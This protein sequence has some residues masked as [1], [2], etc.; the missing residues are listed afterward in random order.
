MLDNAILARLLFA[1]VFIFILRLIHA[2]KL[3][4]GSSWLL[5][6]LGS[7]V[8]LMVVWP[9]SARLF[10]FVT[11]SQDWLL[12]LLFVVVLVLLL[13]VV[14]ASLII[15]NLVSRVKELAQN[16]SL[17]QEEMLNDRLSF[18]RSYQVES[19]D[20]PWGPGDGPQKTETTY[21]EQACG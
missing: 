6:M 12:N 4:I 16:Y 14:H 13:L 17:L 1:G 8:L 9:D 20:E 3:K 19:A 21:R 2:N 11:G 10:S 7:V 5:L 15:S 18:L